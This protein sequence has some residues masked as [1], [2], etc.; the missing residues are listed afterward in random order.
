MCIIVS[1]NR[2]FRNVLNIVK[3]LYVDY[4]VF[5]QFSQGG[6]YEYR[7]KRVTEKGL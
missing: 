3:R 4:T 1:P 7:N 6:K 5:S 2:Y